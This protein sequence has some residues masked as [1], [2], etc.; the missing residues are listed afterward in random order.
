MKVFVTGGSG[1]IGRA[2]ISRARERLW[3]VEAPSRE[4]WNIRIG[5]PMHYTVPSNVDLF[6]HFAANV[7]ARQ[8]IENP[9]D[10]LQ[11]NIVGTFNALE[12]ARQMK[13]QLFVYISSAE[14]LGGC[15]EGYL[16]V[17]APMKPSNPY[18][19]TKGAGELLTYSYFRSY[20]LPAIIVRTQCVWSLNQ[21]D[22]TKAIPIM[23][24]AIESGLVKI[25]TRNGV[26]GSRQWIHVDQFARQLIDLFPTAV[27]GETYHIVGI[28]LNNFE[29]AESIACGLGLSPKYEDQEISPTHEFRYA[30]ESKP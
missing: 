2:F 17:D 27:P 16:G 29:M 22:P 13:P 5:W 26:P 20:K 10:F 3:S 1:F 18:A 15:D 7:K 30:L 21:T 9:R 28:E 24:K 6:V 23:K 12:L 25:Y 19:A 8:S 4:K 14:A 11:D